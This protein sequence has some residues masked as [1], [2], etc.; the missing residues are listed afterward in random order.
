MVTCCEGVD[1]GVI[2]V[3]DIAVVLMMVWIVVVKLVVVWGV[4]VAAEAVMR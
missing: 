4:M 3:R 2:V 1:A